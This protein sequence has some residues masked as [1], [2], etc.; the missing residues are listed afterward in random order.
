MLDKFFDTLWPYTQPK[1]IELSNLEPFVKDYV[2]NRVNDQ[3]NWYDKKSMLSQKKY[4]FFTFVTILCSALT[5]IIANLV[6]PDYTYKL[7]VSILGV[8]VTLSQAIINMSKYNEQWI[9]YRTVCETLK[10]EK[11]MFIANAGVYRDHSDY[12]TFIYFTERI[13]SIISQENVNWANI[14][15]QKQ[16]EK[17]IE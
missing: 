4:K 8:V 7:V 2:V 6:I 15:K 9:E 14:K 5:P 11:Y 17:T 12:E 1:E 16:E 10:Q 3:I 13:E